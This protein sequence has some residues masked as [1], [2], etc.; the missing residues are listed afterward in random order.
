[1]AAPTRVTAPHRPLRYVTV[2]AGRRV[3]PTEL[4]I[5]LIRGYQRIDAELCRPQVRAHVEHE[6]GGGLAGVAGHWLPSMAGGCCAGLR[7]QSNCLR[8][9]L[10]WLG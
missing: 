1:M 3:V 10:L 9:K 4:G 5:T 8:L 7:S 2:E 6:V